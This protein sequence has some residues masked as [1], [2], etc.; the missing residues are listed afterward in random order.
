MH[1][2]IG[3]HRLVEALHLAL[4]IEEAILMALCDKEVELEVAP[5]ELH[6]ACNGRPLAES[7]GLVLSSAIGQR[8]AADDVLLQHISEAFVILV[9]KR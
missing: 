1:W 7:D 4:L 6:T 5:R 8:I 9:K 3:T 2:R